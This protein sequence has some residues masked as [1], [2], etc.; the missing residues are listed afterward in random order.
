MRSERTG[1]HENV[2]SWDILV[3]RQNK[4]LRTS[5]GTPMYVMC[6]YIKSR[7]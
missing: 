2:I 6:K 1:N 4:N 7:E 5:K 3:I